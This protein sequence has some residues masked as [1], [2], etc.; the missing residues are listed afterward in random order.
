MPKKLQT[1]IPGVGFIFRSKYTDR[2][3]NLCE[4]KNWI[5]RLADGTQRA[6]GLSDQADAYAELLKLA[7]Q[8][9][10]GAVTNVR[11]TI[12]ELLDLNLQHSRQNR[13]LA[14]KKSKIEILRKE[15]GAVRLKDFT[16]A[17][18]ERWLERD[19]I[20]NR[21][22]KT[23]PGKLSAA[24]KN[25]FIAEL[26]RSFKLGLKAD[27][28]LCARVPTFPKFEE[29]NV[30]EGFL[31]AADYRKLRDSFAAE[32]SHAR[33]FFVIAYH[34]GMRSGEILRLRWDQIDLAKKLIRLKMGQT[35]NQRP[36]IAPIYG[37]LAAYLEMA[38]A[39]RNKKCDRVI[40][41]E[42]EGVNSIRTAWETACR[43]SGLKLIPHDMRRTAVTNMIEAGIPEAEVMQIVGH[44]SNSMLRRYL[45]SS[46]RG[47]IRAG[48]QMD[49]WAA[50]QTAT[51]EER[52]M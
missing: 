34:L 44:R 52:V 15:F 19:Q 18:V 29:D 5:I 13:S 31:Q 14:D 2:K 10:G 21:G 40:Q 37:E 16:V 43:V 47:A 6:T 48:E 22:Q 17:S 3:G 23:K 28:P 51:R 33:L 12:S 11:G 46:E 4:S 38:S 50:K 9:A 8:N 42:G 45:I 32:A 49:A 27:P 41:F 7:G 20:A 36:R 25:R 39:A 24:T 35:K 26:R 1:S 30:R